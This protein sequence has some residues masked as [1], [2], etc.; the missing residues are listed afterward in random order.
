VTAALAAQASRAGQ[1]M[2]PIEPRI[3]SGPDVGFRVVGI[4]R[5]GE[6]MGRIVIRYNGEWVEPN[7]PME[8][9]LLTQ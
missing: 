3:I 7:A 6:P 8:S 5:R 2:T 1:N 9:R 4:G